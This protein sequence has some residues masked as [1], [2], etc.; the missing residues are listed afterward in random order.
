[1]TYRLRSITERLTKAKTPLAEAL[2]RANLADMAITR[3]A[4]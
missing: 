3:R 2:V 1:M 4:A